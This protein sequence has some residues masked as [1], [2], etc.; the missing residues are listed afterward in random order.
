MVYTQLHY[1]SYSVVFGLNQ[2]NGHTNTNVPVPRECALQL[3]HIGRKN[4]REITE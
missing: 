2:V 3:Q 1:W 4:S